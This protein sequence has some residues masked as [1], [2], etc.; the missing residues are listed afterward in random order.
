MTDTTTT[1]PT[2]VLTTVGDLDSPIWGDER[3]RVVH[4]EGT[5]VAQQVQLYGGL[6]IAAA[7]PWALGKSGLVWACAVVATSAVGNLCYARYITARGVRCHFIFEAGQRGRGA[8]LVAIFAVFAAG[9]LRVE[10]AGSPPSPS[11]SDSLMTGLGFVTA[12]LLGLGVGLAFASVNKRRAQA[13]DVP[14][15]VFTDG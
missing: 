12:I 14:D 3:D 10:F 4:L 6:T 15:D 7:M 13:A 2:P 1:D 8:L 5:A 11:T 9:V